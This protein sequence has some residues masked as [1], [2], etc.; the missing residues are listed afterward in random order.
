MVRSP[1]LLVVGSAQLEKTLADLMAQAKAQPGKLSYASAGIGTATHIPAE[2]FLQDSGLKM[3]HVPYKGNG[4]ALP[5]VV[6]GRVNMMFDAFASSA[7][8]IKGGQLRALAVTSTARLPALPNVPTIAEQGVPRFSYYYWLGIFAPAGTPI[9]VTQRLAEALRSA[10]S[11]SDLKNR[12]QADGTEP[13]LMTTAEFN[14]FVK[15]EVVKT[16]KLVADLGL[17]KE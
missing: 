6:G 8:L 17:P 10:L 15:Q 2:M 14:E 5:D 9:E 4:A 7:T 1:A 12:L 13:L 16:N 3:L 11:G